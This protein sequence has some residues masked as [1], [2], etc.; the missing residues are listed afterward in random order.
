LGRLVTTLDVDVGEDRALRGG[1]EVRDDGWTVMGIVRHHRGKE[2]QATPGLL[3]GK[4]S[5]GIDYGSVAVGPHWAGVDLM[6]FA[7]IADRLV[8]EDGGRARPYSPMAATGLRVRAEAGRSVRAEVDT[9]VRAVHTWAG[10][11]G[12]WLDPGLKSPYGWVRAASSARVAFEPATHPTAVRFWAQGGWVGRDV[13][14]LDELVAGA[15]IPMDPRLDGGWEPLSFPGYPSRSLSGEAATIGGL[16]PS[17]AWRGRAGIGGL[18]LTEV[19]LGPVFHVG[20]LWAR[21]DVGWIRAS[22]AS[23]PLADVGAA[24]RWRA[25]LGIAPWDGFV[26]AA[27][28]LVPARARLSWSLGHLA[29]L[30]EADSARGPTWSVGIGSGW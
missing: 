28:P 8:G 1:L 29:G 5:H 21:S 30:A 14:A 13:G 10:R 18:R 6:G 12:L 22:D 26:M 11:E 15:L 3:E 20:Q 16:E 19:D 27:W 17:V 2:W 9:S 7:E 4:V 25:N 24:L 23:A